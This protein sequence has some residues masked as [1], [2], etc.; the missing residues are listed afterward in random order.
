MSYF[1]VRNTIY[2]VGFKVGWSHTIALQHLVVAVLAQIR[3]H[4]SYVAM[5]QIVIGRDFW[6]N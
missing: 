4:I 5:L 1:V 3:C 6:S 2:S